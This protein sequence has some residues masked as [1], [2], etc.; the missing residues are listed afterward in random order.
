[1]QVIGKLTVLMW[2][3]ALGYLGLYAYGATTGLFSPGEMAAFTVAAV[4]IA[5]LWLVHAVRVTHA[6]RQGE[7][8]AHDEMLR[9]LHRFRETRGF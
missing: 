6:M 3:L 9:N 8:P 2:L 4:V 5:G 7:H 1:M